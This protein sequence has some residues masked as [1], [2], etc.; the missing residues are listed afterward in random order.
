VLVV[1]WQDYHL[2]TKPLLNLSHRTLKMRSIPIIHRL[3]DGLKGKL[4]KDILTLASG[5]ALAQLVSLAFIPLVTRLYGPEAFG[6]LGYYSSL[7]S[8]FT[9]LVGLC[10]PLAIVL[11]KTRIEAQMLFDITVTIGVLIS[12]ITGVALVILDIFFEAFVPFDLAYFWVPV[13]MFFTTLILAST[14][15]AIRHRSFRLISFLAVFAALSGGSLKVLAG[16]LFPTSTALIAVSVLVLMGNF[17]CL[18][19]G[20][21]PRPK[22]KIGNFRRI[23][24]FVVAKRYIRF[25]M[26]RLPH[27]MMA[28]LSQVAPVFL[29][30]A[31]F[32]AS[33]AGYFVLTRTVL[34]APVTLIGKAVHDATYPKINERKVN[35]QSNYFLVIRMTVFLS[36]LSGLPLAIML[37]WGD[38]IFTMIFG[39][40]WEAAG[41]YA[42]WMAIWFAFNFSNK[43]AAAAISVYNL[44]GFLFRN[45]VVNSLFSIFGFMV[46]AMYFESDT[47]SVAL[48]SIFGVL[49][50]VFLIVK[51]IK[52]LGSS[53]ADKVNFRD[54]N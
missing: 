34:S 25:P 28:V 24:Y 41:V 8:F 31:F 10:Y 52:V 51:V 32:G 37:F 15:W 12:F 43:A 27:A 40:Q 19:F 53:N 30:N 26:F 29:L 13:G 54:L 45:G 23:R 49:A 50:Q 20:L 16:F 48:F 39:A 47:V 22:I 3:Q 2:E 4:F 6:G 46:G 21:N 35:G 38:V 42:A 36:L 11:P 17:I 9:P 1:G 5:T 14:Q 44:D 7:I 18:F 33:Y